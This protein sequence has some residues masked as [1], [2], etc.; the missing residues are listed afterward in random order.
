[1]S[2]CKSFSPSERTHI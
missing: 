1:L 2:R